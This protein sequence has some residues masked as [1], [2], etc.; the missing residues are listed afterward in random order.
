MH[1]LQPVRQRGS[2]VDHA[3]VQITAYIV[4]NGLGAGDALPS[5]AEFARQLEVS[6]NAVREAVKS[7]ESTGLLDVRR[8]N[9]LFVKAFSFEPLLTSLPYGLL[10]HERPL[11][12][13]LE[14][15]QILELAL[16][17]RVIDDHADADLKR[18]DATV[19]AMRVKAE[20]GERFQEED[21]AFHRALFAVVGN[22]MIIQ[23][24]DV[25]W[26]AFD[27][28]ST[29]LRLE[30]HDPIATYQLHADIAAAVARRDRAEA[31]RMLE[32]HYSELQARMARALPT[33]DAAAAAAPTADSRGDQ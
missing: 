12:E 1:P 11:V 30:S 10:T 7:L 25:F 33:S 17:D 8:G 20:R 31:H 27:E 6:R 13:L 15:R 9:G 22:Q 16:I 23:L 2:L 4:N 29:R 5:E 21:R 3:R 32:R 18:V 14:L 24:I 26:R 19:R 28:S